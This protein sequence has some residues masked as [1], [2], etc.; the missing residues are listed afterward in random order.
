MSATEGED[1]DL[2]D[3]S[4]RHWDRTD[5]KV[6]VRPRWVRQTD[7]IGRKVR[8]VG[9]DVRRGRMHVDAPTPE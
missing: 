2:D 9:N 6:D 5:A 7:T 8:Q 3:D 1:V 4:V